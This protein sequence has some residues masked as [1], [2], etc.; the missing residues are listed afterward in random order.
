LGITSLRIMRDGRLLIET[1]SK[2]EINLVG[3]NLREECAETLVVNMQILIKRR[4]IIL[5][6][7]TEVSPENILEILHN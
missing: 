5:N 7:P 2:P 4:M 3:Y 1:G 6:T